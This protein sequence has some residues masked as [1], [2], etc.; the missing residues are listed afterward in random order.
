ML[1]LWI[2]VSTMEA[3][4]V[5]CGGGLAFRAYYRRD[6]PAGEGEEEELAS[7]RGHL[8]KVCSARTGIECSPDCVWDE[9]RLFS[10]P[11]MN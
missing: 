5:V 9:H 3:F 1:P 10:M 7:L 4:W 8:K 11:S 6:R 2:Q